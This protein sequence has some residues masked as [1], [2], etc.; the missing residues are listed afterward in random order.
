MRALA[1]IVVVTLAAGAPGAHAQ[2]LPPLPS[3]KDL[4]GKSPETVWESYS[5]QVLASLF[6]T[7]TRLIR[8][9]RVRVI[10][11][12]E[13]VFAAS[14]FAQIYITGG[15]IRSVRNER[16]FAALLAHEFGH[17]LCLHHAASHAPFSFDDVLIAAANNS[18][19]IVE[20]PALRRNEMEA[21]FVSLLANARSQTPLE[22]LGRIIAEQVAPQR[23]LAGPETA[24]DR[25]AKETY[26]LRLQA[27]DH[28]I[29]EK[30]LAPFRRAGP[31]PRRIPSRKAPDADWIACA[32]AMLAAMYPAYA[33]LLARTDIGFLDDIPQ[34]WSNLVEGRGVIL[35]N[36]GY[37]NAVIRKP[38]EFATLLG[39]EFGHIVLKRV[40]EM[41]YRS[42]GVEP[43]DNAIYFRKE[44]E[45]D[46]FA[47]LPLE[48][49]ECAFATV[50]DRS[51]RLMDG[52]IRSLDAPDADPYDRERA[53][54][55][56]AMCV[57]DY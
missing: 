11:A 41:D 49:G 22:L 46:L 37:V 24:Y 45:A 32:R 4:R 8:K 53:N 1:C 51:L 47:T 52:K 3:Q 20:W 38:E 43:T 18:F 17:R 7:R 54:Q 33:D 27:M 5:R 10:V 28:L 50:L 19:D 26:A 48:R 12:D 6:P 25:L 30:Q 39:H 15:F 55:L 35:L 23:A 2:E 44:R 16:E 13:R 21:D 36:R 14:D 9:L 34:A 31:L 57:L 56:R 42:T 29:G 40:L